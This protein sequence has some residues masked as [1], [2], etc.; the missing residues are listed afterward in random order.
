MTQSIPLE[1]LHSF[2]FIV[3]LLFLRGFWTFCCSNKLFSF[4]EV[5]SLLFLRTTQSESSF[6]GFFNEL[7]LL[8]KPNCCK[9][10]LFMPLLLPLSS[11]LEG[12]TL[13]IFP[14]TGGGIVFLLRL[15]TCVACSIVFWSLPFL[16][17]EQGNKGI[18][19][20]A[21]H[22]V[23]HQLLPLTENC[24]WLEC[25]YSRVD[26]PMHKI[27]CLWRAVGVGREYWSSYNSEWSGHLE[28]STP[29]FWLGG[30]ACLWEDSQFPVLSTVMENIAV[31]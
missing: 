20:R 29:F 25:C 14:E 17:R 3:W 31:S 18:W 8:W 16:V 30:S 13:H 23:Y 28:T 12:F 27:P 1:L 22:Q 6:F 9:H 19:L 24:F 5:T 15:P 10:P 11:V 21:L 26:N 7:P 4:W 2:F